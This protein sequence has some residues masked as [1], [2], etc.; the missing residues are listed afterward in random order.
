M[1][2]KISLILVLN[3]VK[4]RVWASGIPLAH[5]CDPAEHPIE[6]RSC[7]Y[8]SLDEWTYT[9]LAK[10]VALAFAYV[11]TPHTLHVRFAVTWTS[12][13]LLWRCSYTDLRIR[14]VST[15]MEKMENTIITDASLR[16]W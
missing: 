12:I 2:E 1:K 13:T 10:I 6:H 5:L 8:P 3:R 16:K 14:V 9:N 4:T 11:Q 15:V 7:V